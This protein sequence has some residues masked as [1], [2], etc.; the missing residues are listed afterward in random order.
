MR[1]EQLTEMPPRLR[2]EIDARVARKAAGLP[3]ARD[4]D[5]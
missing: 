2:A 1:G 3:P 4:D 5:D